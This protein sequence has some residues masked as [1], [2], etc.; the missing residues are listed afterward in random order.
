MIHN[1]N[2]EITQDVLEVSSYFCISVH[3]MN[4]A[5]LHVLPC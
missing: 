4:S 3:N 5:V 1:L 2:A